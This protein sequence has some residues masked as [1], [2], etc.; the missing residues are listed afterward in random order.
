MCFGHF[1]PFYSSPS[2]KESLAYVKLGILRYNSLRAHQW[3]QPNSMLAIL[4]HSL[5]WIPMCTLRVGGLVPRSLEM[6]SSGPNV[7]GSPAP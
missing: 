7:T 1:G 5:C 3:S 2:N 6:I 4:E